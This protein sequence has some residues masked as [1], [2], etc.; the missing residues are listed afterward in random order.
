MPSWNAWQQE[1]Q[2]TVVLKQFSFFI[3]QLQISNR[4]YNVTFHK[5]IRH[6]DLTS[7]V[8]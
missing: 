2:E 5:R 3:H 6:S 1:L 8:P 7:N 4:N